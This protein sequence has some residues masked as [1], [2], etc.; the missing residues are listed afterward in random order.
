MILTCTDCYECQ[1]SDV[2][3][4]AYSPKD[5]LTTLE[6]TL[7]KETADKPLYIQIGCNSFR[8]REAIIKG[9][10]VEE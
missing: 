3:K 7:V 2:C 1:H 6:N 9:K 8:K 4:Y 5:I 10:V